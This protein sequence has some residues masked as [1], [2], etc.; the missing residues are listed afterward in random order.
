[1]V[2]LSSGNRVRSWI[3]NHKYLTMLLYWPLYGL[4]FFS[5]EYL[6]HPGK[7]FVMYV[8]LDDFI[9]F[10]EIFVVPYIIWFLYLIG[11]HLYTVKY[12]VP[13]FKKLMRFIMLSYS[14]TLVVFFLFPTCQE[15]R[16]PEFERNNVFTYLVGAFYRFDTNTNVCPSLHVI[17]SMAVWYAARETKLYKCKGWRLFFQFMTPVICVSTVFLKQHS[18]IDL[19]AGLAVSWVAYRVV[20]RPSSSAH[21]ETWSP[22]PKGLRLHERR[23]VK[24][25]MEG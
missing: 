3:S 8:P 5:L 25:E 2:T 20:Y 1:M 18:I 17:G 7:Y 11:I 22:P 12:D 16:P 13:A 15:L 10:C 4:V 23:M 19:L 14:C 21:L 6:Y 9:P 24:K